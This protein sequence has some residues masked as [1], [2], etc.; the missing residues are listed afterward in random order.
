ME[1]Q[2]DGMLCSILLFDADTNQ[3]HSGAAPSLPEAYTR[4]LQS[5]TIGPT[6]GS[7]GTAAYLRK[8]IVVEDI[9]VDPLWAEYRDLALR[10]ELRLLVQPYPFD[11]RSPSGHLCDVLPAAPPA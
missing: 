4:M 7:C 3:L 11:Q 1:E 5:I 6:V 2:S 8:R 9:A 10:D